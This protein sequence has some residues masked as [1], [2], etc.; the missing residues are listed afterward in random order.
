MVAITGN[1]PIKYRAKAPFKGGFLGSPCPL[2]STGFLV[3]PKAVAQAVHTRF[4]AQSGRPG[5][6]VIDIPKD[7]CLQ[8]QNCSHAHTP[9]QNHVTLRTAQTGKNLEH[10]RSPLV[11]GGGGSD[12]GCVDTFR[13]FVETL[14]APHRA[15]P[16]GLGA[17]PTDHSLLVGMWECT[18]TKRPT[19]VQSCDA[20]LRGRGFDDRVTRHLS[21]LPDARS[22]TLTS[23]LPRLERD[24]TVTSPLSEHSHTASRPDSRPSAIRLAQ[25]LA[26]AAGG[27][28][29]RCARRCQPRNLLV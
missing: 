5:P 8:V 4:I 1:N 25:T 26:G 16:K 3:L 17:L 29:L 12:A 14:Q 9:K 13:N 10:A 24:A 22:Y 11:Y 2:S 20:G 19:A 6:V 27:L 18:A 15:D 7:V 21:S 28:C 23:T